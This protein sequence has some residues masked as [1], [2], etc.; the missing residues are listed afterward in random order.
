MPTA[1]TVADFGKAS[2]ALHKLLHEAAPLTK[3][4][5]D[6]IRTELYTLE[7][8]LDTY[9]SKHPPQEK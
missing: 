8:A 6:F 2:T 9:N 4:Q 1:Q 3:L 5:L 7:V